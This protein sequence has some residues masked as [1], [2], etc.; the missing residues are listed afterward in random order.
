MYQVYTVRSYTQAVEPGWTTQHIILRAQPAVYSDSVS[1]SA[2][3]FLRLCVWGRYIFNLFDGH[4]SD[5]VATC[6]LLAKIYFFVRQ[7][8]T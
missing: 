5:N 2:Y 7:L 1:G 6:F 4:V 3:D 8:S